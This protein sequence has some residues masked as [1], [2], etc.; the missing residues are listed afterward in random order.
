MTWERPERPESRER[1]SGCAW[2]VII[3]LGV[4][5]APAAGAVLMLIFVLALAAMGFT[6]GVL[7]ELGGGAGR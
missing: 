7:D 4:V 1:R 2:I 6:V 3:A 5:L